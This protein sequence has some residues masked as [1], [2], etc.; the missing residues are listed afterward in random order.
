MDFNRNCCRVR[1]LMAEP[2][3]EVR[4][5]WFDRWQAT[6]GSAAAQETREAMTSAW[7]RREKGEA[8]HG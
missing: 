3:L 4:R 6:L 2:R 5:A 1:F 8:A 7:G